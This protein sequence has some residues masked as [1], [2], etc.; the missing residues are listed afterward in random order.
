MPDRDRDE[1]AMEMAVRI[2]AA[3][4]AAAAGRP[5]AVEG[6]EAAGYLRVM[7]DEVRHGLGLVPLAATRG[8]I[9]CASPSSPTR[10]SPG[11]GPGELP[12]A[13]RAALVGA[14]LIVHAGDLADMAALA[15]L[16][17]LGPPLV[18]VHGNADQPAVRAA[19]PATAAVD[20]P[21]LR[22][23]VDPRRRAPRPAAWPACAA[24]SPSAGAV[25]FG[26]S[27]VPLLAPRGGLP[28]PQPG[29]PDGPAA[30][31]AALDGRAAGRGGPP[32]RGALPGG[33]RPRRAAAAGAG[34]HGVVGSPGGP[35]RH[36]P[37]YGRLGAQRRARHLGDARH[38]RGRPLAGR[39]RRGHPA[40]VPA[41]RPGADGPRPHPAHAPARRPRAGP[42]RAAEDLRPARARGTPPPDRAARA[43]G[44]APGLRPGHRPAALPAPGP[45]GGTRP[46]VDGG[47]APRYTPTRPTT[48][49]RS[50]GYALVEDPRPGEFDVAAARALGVP[51]GPALGPAAA[52][53]RGRRAG[54]A[55]VR[56]DAGARRAAAGPRGWSSPAT[57]A[58]AR[59]PSR[60]RAAPT[61][62]CTRRPCSTR[63]AS[64][65]W[66]PGTRPC[67]RRPPWAA[68]RRCACWRSPTCPA[69]SAPGRRAARPSAS[70]TGWSSPRDF[71]QIEIPFPER[72]GPRLLPAEPGP[73]P[74]RA[75]T[76]VAAEEPATVPPTTFNPAP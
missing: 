63:T 7:V 71:D 3:R 67:W 40:P 62:W 9:G 23:A 10:T 74:R 76:T 38:P 31:A 72:G 52:G 18:A 36:L 26:H 45:R 29:E 34:A 27:H 50:Q 73:A 68:R 49:C 75:R 15:M 42:A 70:S 22:L 48:G 30:P 57:R 1:V 17:A 61:C 41:L 66:R 43:P 39:L 5:N 6:R 24:A 4:V 37:G 47:A 11:G 46:G 14:D 54:R 56:P 55:V 51:E 64:G 60:P 59:R 33:G 16:R 20:L 69:A 53:R 65:P 58:P 32:A 21:G 12:P 28:H 13:C 44:P 19:L 35:A 2:L 8:L 25:V